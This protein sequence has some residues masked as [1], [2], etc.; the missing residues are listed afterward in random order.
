MDCQVAAISCRSC[1]FRAFF[2]RT[3]R[4]SRPPVHIF[5]PKVRKS[6]EIPLD[7]HLAPAAMN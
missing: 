1:R 6:P 7:D 3:D 5:M 2:S 4:K